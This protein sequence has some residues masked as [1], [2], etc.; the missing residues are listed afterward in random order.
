MVTDTFDET[1]SEL[2]EIKAGAERETVRTAIGQLADYVRFLPPE[3]TTGIVL[4]RSPDA[5]LVDLIRTTGHRLL[6][7]DG[8]EF[9]EVLGDSEG[10]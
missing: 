2:W 5:D 8:Q 7:P 1:T 9:V 6:V 3:V 10:S 4:P